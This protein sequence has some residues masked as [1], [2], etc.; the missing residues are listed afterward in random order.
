[1]ENEIKTEIHYPIPP[2]KQN[3]IS[4]VLEGENMVADILHKTEISLPISFGN[5][6][7]EIK[8]ICEIINNFAVCKTAL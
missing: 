2:H 5:S 8:T 3:A 1:L 4:R 6:K 7:T